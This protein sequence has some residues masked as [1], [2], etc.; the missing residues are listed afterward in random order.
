MEKRQE[1][2]IEQLMKACGE[3]IKNADRSAIGIVEKEGHANF[4]TKYDK[5]VQEKLKEGLA[6]IFPEA[7]FVGEESENTPNIEK[8]YAFIVDPIDGTTNFIKDFRNSCISVAL[9]YDAKPIWGAVYNPYTDEFF[10]A[11][12]GCGAYLNEKSIHVSDGRLEDALVLFGTA[13]Y[14]DKLRDKSMQ[15][16]KEYLEKAA[17][18]RRSGSAALD[19]CAVAAGRAE[20]FFEYLLQPWDY[21]AGMLIVAEAGGSVTDTEGNPLPVIEKSSVMAQGSG[22]HLSRL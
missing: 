4:V 13:P 17:D 21:A 11:K 22:L 14:Y 10:R 19:L 16:A 7:V 15:K 2:E 18:I 5:L 6:E 20:L 3:I 1:T 9:V 12:K 8:G